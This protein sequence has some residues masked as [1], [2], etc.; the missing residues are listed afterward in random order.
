M[1]RELFAAR[2]RTP[3]QLFAVL[4]YAV[5]APS[6][7]NTQPWRFRVTTDALELFADRAR[8]LPAVDPCD[9]ELVMSCGA[10][11]FHARIALRRFGFR[12]DVELFP[13]PAHQDFLARVRPAEPYEPS[14]EERALFDAI[15][16]RHTY[17]F[18]FESRPIPLQL[19]AELQEAASQEGAWLRILE[20]ERVRGTVASLIMQGDRIQM[21][22]PEIRRELA[23]WTR[24]N[25]SRVTDGIP[26]N[27]LGFGDLKAAAGPLV[28][29]TFDLGR[30]QAARDRDLALASPVLAVLGSFAESPY[31]WVS[32]GQALAR[33][34]LRARIDGVCASFLNQ[35]IEVPTLRTQLEALT[36]ARRF[37]QLLLRLG[38]GKDTAATPRRPLEDVLI[39]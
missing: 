28:L 13:D 32:T 38:Y 36:G 22:D 23:A 9:R 27:A 1:T 17:R 35:P 25:S 31:D 21:A 24:P 12:D 4:E 15:P 6:S 39:D 37:P 30:G 5:L 19:V 16:R 34:L 33:V 11:L 2:S 8:A 18:A 14:D 7:H 26:G 3:A 10:A 20:G 29:R